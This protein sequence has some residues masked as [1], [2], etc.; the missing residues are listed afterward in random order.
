MSNQDEDEVEDELELLEKEVNGTK[1]VGNKIILPDTP[2]KEPELTPEQKAQIARERAQRRARE[3]A[4]KEEERAEPI[5][6]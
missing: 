2:E 6:A 4:A 1:D 3:R 5:L